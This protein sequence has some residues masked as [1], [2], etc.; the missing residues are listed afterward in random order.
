MLTQKNPGIENFNTPKILQ[1]PQ[2]LE[3]WSPAPPPHSIDSEKPTVIRSS[4]ICTIQHD[5]RRSVLLL[6]GCPHCRG[7]IGFVQA[8]NGFAASSQWVPDMQ[9]CTLLLHFPLSDAIFLKTWAL[10]RL[11]SRGLTAIELTKTVC[12]QGPGAHFCARAQGLDLVL[13]HRHRAR[14]LAWVCLKKRVCSHQ[15]PA[16]TVLGH[17]VRAPSVKAALLF[18]VQQRK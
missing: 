13:G 1:S 10:Q 6:S 14:I 12:T 16:S 7:I 5:T 2:S 15:Y 11:Q 9:L 4:K 3:I 18:R 8:R 17:R